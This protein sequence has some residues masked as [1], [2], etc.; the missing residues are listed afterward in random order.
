MPT[1]LMQEMNITEQLIEPSFAEALA[2]IEVAED[3]TETRR[4]HWRCSLRVI[5]KALGG[6]RNFCRRGGRPS[7]YRSRACTTS[8]WT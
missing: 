8:K 1:L 3:L 7:E 5:A 4:R 6:R 2:A